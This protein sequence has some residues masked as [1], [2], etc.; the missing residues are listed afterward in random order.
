[1]VMGT[2]YTLMDQKDMQFEAKH[3][4]HSGEEG[5]HFWSSSSDGRELPVNGHELYV[6]LQ[7]RS[8]SRSA[9]V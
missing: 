2:K 7:S 4:L 5:L 1:M 3:C 8:E 6:V 9:G